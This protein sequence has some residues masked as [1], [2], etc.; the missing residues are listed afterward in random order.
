MFRLRLPGDRN[1][2][3]DD[4]DDDDEFASIVDSVLGDDD[5]A[6]Q[7]T[8]S[9]SDVDMQ[10]PELIGRAPYSPRQAGHRDCD[11]DLEEYAYAVARSR[12]QAL[13]IGDEPEIRVTIDV[14]A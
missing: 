3:G 4:L 13:D 5:V 7:F 8:E 14:D 1:A 11:Q 9:D 6:S 12:S 2:C 10:D